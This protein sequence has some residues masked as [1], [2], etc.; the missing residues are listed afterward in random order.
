MGVNFPILYC[1]ATRIL[2][3]LLKIEVKPGR[4]YY[5]QHE[6]KGTEHLHVVLLFQ[7]E[8]R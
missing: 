2:R 3:S 7:Q 6:E 1:Y 8:S 5:K 4:D